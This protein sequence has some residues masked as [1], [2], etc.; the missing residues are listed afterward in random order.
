M[1]YSAFVA[2]SPATCLAY[3]KGRQNGLFHALN[4]LSL[5]LSDSTAFC[6]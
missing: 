6:G 4:C 5:S 2:Y 1:V 3:G